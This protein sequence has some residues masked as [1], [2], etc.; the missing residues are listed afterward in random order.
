MKKLRYLIIVLFLIMLLSS[1]VN[2][3]KKSSSGST[4]GSAIGTKVTEL[5]PKDITYE[6]GNVT[7]TGISD[8]ADL[9]KLYLYDTLFVTIQYS[10]ASKNTVSHRRTIA[11]N[12]VKGSSIDFKVEVIDKSNNYGEL[13]KSIPYLGYVDKDTIEVGERYI[14]F[15]ALPN[16]SK[17]KIKIGTE[18]KIYDSNEIELNYSLNDKVDT[19]DDTLNID[20][21]P[22]SDSLYFAHTTSYKYS[23]I[24]TVSELKF[25]NNK[26][27][28][29]S[30]YYDGKWRIVINE[31]NEIVDEIINAQAF[32]YTPNGS[33]FT[34]TV[35]AYKNDHPTAEV[36]ISVKAIPNFDTITFD[37]KYIMI[38][39]DTETSNRSFNY[40]LKVKNEIVS[41]GTASARGINYD[42]NYYK[43]LGNDVTLTINKAVGENEYLIGETTFDLKCINDYYVSSIRSNSNTVNNELAYRINNK[44]PSSIVHASLYN[45]NNEVVDSIDVEFSKYIDSKEI[46]LHYNTP[47][48]YKL[49]VS[50]EL[51]EADNR[52]IMNLD[53]LKGDYEVIYDIP[54][55][56]DVDS[57]ENNNDNVIV[58]AKDL[59]DMSV[60]LY[61]GS[62]F[63]S[64]NSGTDKTYSIKE[65]SFSTAKEYDLFF[66]SK[67]FTKEEPVLCTKYSK[68]GSTFYISTDYPL[69]TYRVELYNENNVFLGTKLTTDS[70][71]HSFNLSGKSYNQVYMVFT[72]ENTYSSKFNITKIDT[73]TLSINENTL[74]FSGG[75]NYCLTDGDNVIYDKTELEEYLINYDN[76]KHSFKLKAIADNSKFEINSSFTAKMDIK[77]IDNPVIEVY[78]QTISW[79][80]LK[81]TGFNYDVYI[82]DSLTNIDETEI[83]ISSYINANNQIAFSVIAKSESIYTLSSQKISYTI[84]KRIATNYI[85]NLGISNQNKAVIFTSSQN[86]SYSYY[87]YDEN[88]NLIVRNTTN[89]TSIPVE[90]TPGEYRIDLSIASTI[91]ND[92]HTIEMT[93]TEKVG[94]VFIQ[95]GISSISRST[96]SKYNIERITSDTTDVLF[97]LYVDDNYNVNTTNN[98]F[99]VNLSN[100]E[101]GTHSI[102][103]KDD[104]T[105]SLADSQKRFKFSDYVFEQEIVK[106][107]KLTLTK[108]IN[109]PSYTLPLGSAL[110]IPLTYTTI[111]SAGGNTTTFTSIEYTR[112]FNQYY[113]YSYAVSNSIAV[114]LEDTK[115]SSSTSYNFNADE[116]VYRVY[117]RVIADDFRNNSDEYT[118]TGDKG[119]IDFSINKLIE[120]INIGIKNGSS[121][122]DRN[123]LL[124]INI[125]SGSIYPYN[126]ANSGYHFRVEVSGAGTFEWDPIRK[127]QILNYTITKGNA[128]ITPGVNIGKV[129][130]DGDR[131][132]ITLYIYHDYGES[133][134]LTFTNLAVYYSIAAYGYVPNN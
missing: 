34:I 69:D 53:R 22:Y 68:T 86:E 79:D 119:Y 113:L 57:I 15:G 10:A 120:K 54:N 128:S 49:V 33:D 126:Q 118:L 66:V 50:R 63:V 52:L 14:K 16:V 6:D 28:F 9:V 111:I 80:N 32:D 81:G 35:N 129:L 112:Y 13:S 77:F 94:L 7:V 105:N 122:S 4:S 125:P 88:S 65:S 31:N 110:T 11:K 30:P 67:K 48:T 8:N 26:I 104:S 114:T 56:I 74:S 84:N 38:S 1:C 3:N 107:P 2:I 95:D 21:T 85:T 29:K 75:D 12:E 51:V 97:K 83:D 36:S 70:N 46:V 96:G 59:Q 24:S 19:K 109:Y 76:L 106:A 133:A 78:D 73:P 115:V 39:D 43:Y 55:E 5:N 62:S 98:T 91:D 72:K 44:Y 132:N 99:T 42:S 108:R 25:S 41:S 134:R 89:L 100:Q 47:D 93:S 123:G 40:Q 117:A 121:G 131:V 102:K 64:T 23:K 61:L 18:E 90:L 87:I 71:S 60:S 37:E 103:I 20:I 116:G 127:G 92:T 27:T 58:K 82:N 130:V 45:S 101:A 17:Y 124:Y